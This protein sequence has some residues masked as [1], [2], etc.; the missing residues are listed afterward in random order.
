MMNFQWLPYVEMLARSILSLI[1]SNNGLFK[2]YKQREFINKQKKNSSKDAETA[3]KY[4]G[5][6]FPYPEQSGWLAEGEIR[7]VDYGL[8]SYRR[9]GHFFVFDQYG[10]VKQYKIH[11]TYQDDNTFSF[12]NPNKTE[13]IWERPEGVEI[14]DLTPPP[15]PQVVGEYVGA[16]GDKVVSEVLIKEVIYIGETRWGPK[17]LT[18]LVDAN[19]NVLQ[20]W[21][22]LRRDAD[23]N[24]P[25]MLAFKVKGHEEYRST[26]ITTISYPKIKEN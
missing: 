23:D 2:S 22:L 7:W 9:V 10:V 12:P 14:P 19:S 15:E 25:F 11:Y 8:R 4:F 16:V 21:G 26:K 17:F 5:V 6:S 18:K 20:Y 24:T 13:L 1:K 3:L